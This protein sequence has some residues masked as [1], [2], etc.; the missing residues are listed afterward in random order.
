MVSLSKEN[1]VHGEV[2]PRAVEVVHLLTEEETVA[3]MAK[4]SPKA[5]SITIEVQQTA[6]PPAVKT[7]DLDAQLE[8]AHKETDTMLTAFGWAVTVIFAL[9]F[10]FTTVLSK[11][12]DGYELA[13]G[14]ARVASCILMGSTA[15][16][17]MFQTLHVPPL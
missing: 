8:Q 13:F 14:V 2:A 6:A 1:A 10:V 3:Q 17:A 5:A 15:C 4:T 16:T 11:L 12:V 7:D 9:L